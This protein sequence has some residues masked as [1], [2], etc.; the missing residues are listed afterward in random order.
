M[1]V[2]SFPQHFV[3]AGVR[4]TPAQPECQEGDVCF[5][6]LLP[7]CAGTEVLVVL[8]AAVQAPVITLNMSSVHL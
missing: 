2:P 7:H 4:H 3:R 6:Q 5:V 8:L 1:T